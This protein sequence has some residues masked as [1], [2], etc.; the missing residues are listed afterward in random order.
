MAT[1]AKVRKLE[2]DAHKRSQQRTE[3]RNELAAHAILALSEL[4]YART[5]L[6]DIAALS[7]RSVGAL[8]YYFDDKNHLI[9]YCV[10]LYKQEFIGHIDAAMQGHSDPAQVG[11][12]VAGAFAWAIE[13]DARKH[14][15]WYDI[16]SQA[17]FEEAFRP[18]V[19]EIE[20]GLQAMVERFL[21][22]L[23]RPTDQAG[24]LYFLLDGLFRTHLQSVLAGD[25][26]A[27]ARLRAATLDTLANL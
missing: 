14:R 27:P 2:A 5:G 17:L 19:A 3:A 9:A 18:V 16:R 4:G 1:V 15:L 13:H 6:R 8:S 22:E 11:E 24:N 10:R 23:G 26:T 7:G 20:G 25:A 21:R 12:A